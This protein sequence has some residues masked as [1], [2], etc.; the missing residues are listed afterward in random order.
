MFSEDGTLLAPVPAAFQSVRDAYAGCH[1]YRDRGTVVS[2]G[3]FLDGSVSVTVGRFDT[4]F[5]R[6]RGLAFRFYDEEGTLTHALWEWDGQ[7]QEWSMGV[8]SRVN[9]SSV[10]EVMS[11][12]MRGVTSLTSCYVPSLLFGRA[13][14]AD[15]GSWNVRPESWERF[16][17][18]V[19][20]TASRDITTEFS[21]DLRARVLRR[22]HRV[23]RVSVEEASMLSAHAA[24]LTRPPMAV[25]LPSRT[26]KLILYESPT[27]DAGEGGLAEELAKQPW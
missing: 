16:T 17:T 23:V 1:A 26:E 3:W 8:V 20:A 13:P 12:I 25:P 22:V 19:F 11:E 7:A 18:V 10:L 14:E 9:V 2:T 27:C 4:R 6:G 24:A 21:V 5:L 15:S